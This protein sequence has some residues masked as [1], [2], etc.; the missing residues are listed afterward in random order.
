MD[1]GEPRSAAP[2]TWLAAAFA[3]AGC[4]AATHIGADARWLAA[5][6]ASIAHTGALPH[7]IGYAAAPSSW[8]DAP[9]LG[10]LVSHALER[11]GGDRGL[12]VAQ[13]VAVAIAVAA[14]AV[15][16]GRREARDGAGAAVLLAT[17][18]AA[19]AAFLIARAEVF[20]LA[21]FP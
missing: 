14:L 7:T 1:D 15:D 18:A 4:A 6:G 10:Q 3:A 8:H 21:L 2:L 16:I 11:A 19:P 9:A 17:V 20:S 13:V 12:V 5:I